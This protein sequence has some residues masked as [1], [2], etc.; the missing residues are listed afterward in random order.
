[1]APYRIDAA[2]SSFENMNSVETGNMAGMPEQV[3]VF[4]RADALAE[5]EQLADTL[6]LVEIE[7]SRS[8]PADLVS[9]A[10]IAVVEVDPTSRQSVARLDALRAARPELA[11]IAGLPQVDLSITRLM[12]RK[13]IGDVVAMPFTVDELL[14]AVLEIERETGGSEPRAS[15]ALAPVVA[16]QKCVGGAGATTIATHLAEFLS[17]ELGDHRRVCLIDLDVQSGDAASYLDRHSRKSLIDLLEAGRRLD[18]E[19]FNSVALEVNANFDVISAPGDIIPIE[20]I[21]LSSLKS[22]IDLARHRYDLVLLDMP[23]SL[24]NWAMSAMLA[25]DAVLLVGNSSISALRQVKRRL[26]LLDSFS[27]RNGRIAIALN[28]TSSG[29]FNKVDKSGIE[30]ALG[31][32]IAR[33]VHSDTQLIQEAQARGVLAMDIQRRSRFASDIEALADYLL[34]LVEES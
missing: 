20:E 13:G 28:N 24:T 33:L 17:N 1:M 29:L 9:R 18:T 16:V 31:H 2:M 7:P 11:I 14:S 15:V 6:T 26:Q 21:E 34:A 12:L 5:L 22:V 32:P 27:F 4:A 25:S 3:F 8:L 30:D 19:L 23:A 10:R